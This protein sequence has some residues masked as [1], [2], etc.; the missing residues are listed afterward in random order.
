VRPCRDCR[1]GER[2]SRSNRKTLPLVRPGI[3]TDS[4]HSAA[5][6]IKSALCRCVS[7][8]ALI[9][10]CLPSR[11]LA[12]P[13]RRGPSGCHANDG[14]SHQGGNDRARLRKASRAGRATTTEAAISVDACIALG[15]AS[16]AILLLLRST[17]FAQT[18]PA[19]A[20]SVVT[21]ATGNKFQRVLAASG[22]QRRMLR[23]SNNN[24]NGDACWVFVGS[25]RASKEDSYAAAPGKEYLRYPPF[26]TSDAIQATC[27]SSSDTLDVE[28][29]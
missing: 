15:V 19:P 26:V 9:E 10:P 21:I 29:Q 16:V 25:G 24:T 1:S 28:Y 13:G 7:V 6:P 20:D 3:P 14:P 12:R 8:P 22:T 23:I 5:A 18:P 27:A 4:T 2:K 17:T 11:V